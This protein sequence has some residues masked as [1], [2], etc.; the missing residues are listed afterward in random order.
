VLAEL[1]QEQGKPE[2]FERSGRLRGRATTGAFPSNFKAILG[3]SEYLFSLLPQQLT[4]TFQVLPGFTVFC[5]LTQRLKRAKIYVGT[6]RNAPSIWVH[7]DPS[8]AYF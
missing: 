5:L 8:G 6:V 7:P 4:S 3:V 1:L 2:I